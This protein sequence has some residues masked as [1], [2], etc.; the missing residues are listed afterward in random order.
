MGTGS[1]GQ[2]RTC[3]RARGR[4]RGDCSP[5]HH[6]A[7]REARG[8]SHRD[9]GR[10]ALGDRGGERDHHRVAGRLQR[11]LGRD[12]GDHRD[13]DP[14]P[15]RRRVDDGDAT[16]TTATAGAH[17]VSRARR[18][19]ESRRRTGSHRVA[20]RLQRDLS[21]D[22]GDHRDHDPGPERRGGG[23]DAHDDDCRADSAPATVPASWT[24]AIYSPLG[25]AYLASNAAAAWEPRCARRGSRP[26]RDRHLSRR[27][28]LGLPHL[29]AAGLPLRP[30]PRRARRAR[31]PARHAHRTSTGPRSTSRAP[32]CAR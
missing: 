19:R 8:R 10:D 14:G 24:T 3:G 11:D 30:L 9:R 6:A 20:G 29:G 31:Q 28:A 13:H 12:P 32:R 27:L 25:A 23:D 15:E 5:A 1:G 4:G 2:R 17:T 26:V 18:S 22:P 7:D 16:T 21:R